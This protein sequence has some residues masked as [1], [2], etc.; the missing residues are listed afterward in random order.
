MVV[1]AES[2]M[3]LLASVREKE[4]ITVHLHM[5]VTYWYGDSVP[6]HFYYRPPM[7]HAHHSFPLIGQQILRFHSQASLI[8]KGFVL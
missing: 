4:I 5:L 2:G 3:P 8:I 1:L 7:E 6:H